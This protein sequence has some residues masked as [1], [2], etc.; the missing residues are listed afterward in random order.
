MSRFQNRTIW[1]D[2]TVIQADGG[3]RTAAVNGGF[4]AL[5]GALQHMQEQ[6]DIDRVP[7][8]N[9]VCA[10]SVGKVDAGML[11]D[12]AAGEDKRAEVDMNVVMNHECELV[13]LQGTAEGQPFPREELDELVDLAQGAVPALRDAQMEITG[14]L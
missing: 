9:G 6:D 1:I 5:V 14:D 8:Q 7:V 12:L 3:T 13:E 11:L 10:V 4:V 2:C